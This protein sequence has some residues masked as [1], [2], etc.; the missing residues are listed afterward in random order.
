MS[1]CPLKRV[2]HRGTAILAVWCSLHG[3]DARATK[4]VNGYFSNAS[5]KVRLTNDKEADKI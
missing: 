5:A 4:M 3:Q 1:N 2:T